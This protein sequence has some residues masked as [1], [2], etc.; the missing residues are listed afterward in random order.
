MQ[1]TVVKEFENNPDVEVFIFDQGGSSG[2]TRDWLETWWDNYFLRGSVVYDQSGS[3]GTQYGQP[4]TNLPFGRGFIIDRDGT[5]A[6]AYFGHKP[7]WVIDQIYGLLDGGPTVG[8]ELSCVPASGTV[9][10]QTLLTISLDNLYTGQTRRLAGRIDVTLA[11]G[12]YIPSWRAGYTNVAP[13]AS[14]ASAFSVTIPALGSVIGN[15]DFL[16]L[17]EDVTPPPY[18]QPPYPAAGDTATDGCTVTGIA[19]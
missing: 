15:N 8:A 17:A 12:T 7:A 14:F 16:L 9:P 10:F 18:N 4:K 1:N 11:G 19:P 3:V 2:E 13:G 5:V 6:Q